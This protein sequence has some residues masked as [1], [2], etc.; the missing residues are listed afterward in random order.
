MGPNVS[1]P[2]D[3]KG[4]CR[5]RRESVESP[6][7]NNASKFMRR[8]K[9]PDNLDD[10]R[11]T[12]NEKAICQNPSEEPIDGEPDDSEMTASSRKTTSEDTIFEES[13]YCHTSIMQTFK[14]TISYLLRS[15]DHKGDQRIT[16]TCECGEDLYADFK[17]KSPETT[18]DIH[19]ILHDVPSAAMYE[20]RIF[21][22]G[23]SRAFIF[24]ILSKVPNPEASFSGHAHSVTNTFPSTSQALTT[25]TPKSLVLISTTSNSSSL[26]LSTLKSS[27]L[28][29]SAWR[30]ATFPELCV[31]AGE[32]LKKLGEINLVYTKLDDDM[33][34]RIPEKYFELRGARAKS[35]LVKPAS[36]S[37]VR[38]SV[39]QRH[40]LGILQKPFSL[41]PKIEVDQGRWTYDPCPL[42]EGELPVPE[43]VILHYLKCTSPTSILF[44]M[45][46]ISRKCKTRI[47]DNE[48]API[49]LGWGIHIDESPNYKVIFFINSVA[50]VI[51]GSIALVWSLAKVDFQGAFG[52]ASWFIASVNAMLLTLMY[53]LN[54]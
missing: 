13:I 44:G 12:R 52:F 39:E 19:A 38:F 25:L 1:A 33:F 20:L 9:T 17:T 2:G 10:I 30:D 54:K 48:A 37:F 7:G 41:P 36:V 22:T 28:T 51:S 5:S 14:N 43:N 29:L 35:W 46:R 47:L 15:R 42:D 53:W 8:S 34:K 24:T 4:T 16:W 32:N 49:A 26:I 18:R 50:L 40:S 6:N 45:R 27:V 31:N 11:S 3:L 21:P 23:A